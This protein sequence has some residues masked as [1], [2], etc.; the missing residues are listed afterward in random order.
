MAISLISAFKKLLV[1]HYLLSDGS[2]KKLLFILPASIWGTVYMTNMY[3]P[4]RFIAKGS[5]ASKLSAIK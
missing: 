3:R 2:A 5:K 4:N 1:D